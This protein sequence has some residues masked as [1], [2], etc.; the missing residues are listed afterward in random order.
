MRHPTVYILECADS[1]YYTGSTTNLGQRMIQHESGVVPGFTSQRLPIRLMYTIECQT[2]AEAAAIEKQIKRWSHQKKK[3]LIE[4]RI[5]LLKAL[6]ECRNET[7]FRRK[8]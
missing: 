5:D 3:A 4:G 8:L 2:I 6:A 7:H 1:L